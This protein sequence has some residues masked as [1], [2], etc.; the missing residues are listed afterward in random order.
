[1]SQ[2]GVSPEQLV[3]LVQPARQ[4]N[5]CGSQ[6]GAAAP[7]SELARHSTHC[8]DDSRQRGAEAGQ[9]LFWPHCTHWL[10]VESQMGVPPPQSFA[11]SQPTHWPV[12]DV[13]LQIGVFIGHVAADVHAA[14]H[15]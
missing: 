8:P 6:M 10:V 9:S 15:W 12:P 14:W 13:V 11:D 7:Q 2:S 3:L 4:R 1:M 5:W